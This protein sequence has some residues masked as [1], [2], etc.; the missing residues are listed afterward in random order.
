MPDGFYY[1][2][3][4]VYYYKSGIMRTG[5]QKIKG[6]KYYFSKKNGV[7]Q[8]NCIA[9]TKNTGFYYVDENGIQVTAPEIKAAV[10]YVKKYTK[11]TQTNKVKLQKCYQALRNNYHYQGSQDI[12]TV[13]K[14][15]S[16]AYDLLTYGKGNCYRY[17]T[18]FA[19]IAKVLG[20]KV[21]INIGKISSR[22]GGTTEHG[23]AEVKSDGVWH[24]CNINMNL[25]MHTGK[26]SRKYK[27][28]ERYKLIIEDGKVFWQ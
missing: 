4:E 27:Y 21:L 26:T 13:K 15:S 11:N 7:M 9:G 10:K 20:Y 17:A 16:Y 24:K 2:E 6:R 23:W 14:F 28:T 19:C 25:Y 3:D 8:T 5:W 12:P 22:Y 1:T 18:G